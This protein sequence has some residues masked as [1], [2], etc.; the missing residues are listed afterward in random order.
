MPFTGSPCASPFRP[1][2]ATRLP[3]GQGR[4]IIGMA[5]VRSAFETQER[6]P[7]DD[8]G[9]IGMAQVRF[10][11]HSHRHG[12]RRRPGRHA[13]GDAPSFTR[14][15]ISP[16]IADP[17]TGTLPRAVTRSAVRCPAASA[18]PIAR[19]TASAS[20][21]APR[22]CRNSMAAEAMAPMGLAASR[23]AS[24]GADPWTGSNNPAAAADARG[25]QESQRADHGAGLVRENVPEEVAGQHDVELLGFVASRR[26]QASTY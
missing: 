2:A 23:P 9:I 25:R 4:G 13:S 3:A 24:V 19:S 6:G 14:A 11:R 17:L 12:R 8:G 5:Q 7:R 21:C 26:A 1:R 18:E 10:R 15:A 16:A 22:A 20:A